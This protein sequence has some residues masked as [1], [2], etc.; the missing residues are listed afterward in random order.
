MINWLQPSKIPEVAKYIECYWLIEKR[1]DAKSL[2]Y[3]KLNPDPSAHLIISPAKQN[4]YYNMNPGAAVGKG[5][6][7]LFPHHQT[8][9]LDHSKPFIHLGIKFRIGAFYSLKLFSGQQPLLDC[10]EEVQ[11]S[12]LFS[13]QS[14]GEMKLI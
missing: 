5:S 13:E 9:Q 8:L 6:H 7:W 14:E 3:P 4:Y 11:L 12:K 10:V 2:D 1:F